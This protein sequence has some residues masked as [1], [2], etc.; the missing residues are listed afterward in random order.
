MLVY[1]HESLETINIIKLRVK[2]DVFSKSSFFSN[3]S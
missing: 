3:I 2:F 1:K